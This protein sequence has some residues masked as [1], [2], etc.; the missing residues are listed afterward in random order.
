MADNFTDILEEVG[1]FEIPAQLEKF[2]AR[3]R[4]PSE[5]EQTLAYYSYSYELAFRQ[6]AGSIKARWRS[7]GL[8]QAP[9]FYLARHSIELHLKY[10]IEEFVSFTG[11]PAR[12]GGHDLLV[13]WNELKRQFQLAQL[14]EED[15]WG[16][17][18]ERLI[19]HMHGFDPKGD[20]FRYP[21][22]VAR[23]QFKYTRVEFDGLV[24]AHEHITGYCGAS[25]DVLEEY[26]NAY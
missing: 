11:E 10:A 23:K 13:L 14:P 1:E 9:L 2:L 22:N 5:S 21:H 12:D 7:N 4:P 24:K 17:C 18:V 25:L 8:M 19:K 26:R 16:V 6:L 20:A 15:V 3:E